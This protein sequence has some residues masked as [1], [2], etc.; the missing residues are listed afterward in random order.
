M[1]SPKDT[2]IENVYFWFSLGFLLSRIL[3]VIVIA[4]RLNEE[5]KKPIAVLR[6][7]PMNHFNIEVIMQFRQYQIKL[8]TTIYAMQAK[9]FLEQVVSTEIAFTGMGFFRINRRLIL[10]VRKESNFR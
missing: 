4:A 8:L 2:A 3:F 1:L 6:A 10:G 7:I 9:R 5:S